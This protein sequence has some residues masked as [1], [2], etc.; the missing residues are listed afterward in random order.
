M[1]KTKPFKL[2]L[3]LKSGKS[4][5]SFIDAGNLRDAVTRALNTSLLISSD[6][7]IIPG[8]SVETFKVVTLDESNMAE[9]AAYAETNLQ[10]LKDLRMA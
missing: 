10:L 6:G 1:S 2:E 8:A 3:T 7:F 5:T 4:L 9:Y